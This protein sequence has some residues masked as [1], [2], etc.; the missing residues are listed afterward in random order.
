[1]R[2]LWLEQSLA[3]VR[4]EDDWFSAW[5]TSHLG[6]LRFP[7]RR[8]DWRLGRWTAKRA[9]AAY[10]ELPH[11]PGILATIEIRPA[12][13]GAPEV[14]IE[15]APGDVSISLSHRGGIAACAVGEPDAV[16]GCDVEVVEPRSDAFV[17]DYFTAEEQAMTRQAAEPARFALIALIWSAK[18]SALKALGTGLRSD[19][20]CVS[21]AINESCVSALDDT[22]SPACENS[23]PLLGGDSLWRPLRV[24]Y[25][26]EQVFR[27][28]WFCRDGLLRTMVS[29]RSTQELIA[30]ETH[31]TDLRPSDHARGDPA[32]GT[33][34]HPAPHP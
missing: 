18:E 28:W 22:K 23:P 2:V 6:S 25:G 9:I 30:P 17:G 7:K 32:P 31:G 10:L 1:M 13:S 15:A 12:A 29:D 14:F 26:E 21:V 34:V 27:G 3:D 16:L 4:T 33:P 8:A 20:R 24:R 5:E 11:D 19:T